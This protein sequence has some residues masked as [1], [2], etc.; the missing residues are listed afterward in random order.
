MSKLTD[1]VFSGDAKLADYINAYIGVNM[2]DLVC[3]TIIDGDHEMFKKFMELGVDV[4]GTDSSKNKSCM[5]MC[6][7]QKGR[8]EMLEI[9]LSRGM[10]IDSYAESALR[11]ITNVADSEFSENH[12]KCI[13]ILIRA[14]VSVDSLKDSSN[15]KYLLI[16]TIKEL[17]FEPK[18]L[19][20]SS[21]LFC[22]NQKVSEV[23]DDV[24][25]IRAVYNK[26]NCETH[27][28]IMNVNYHYIMIYDIF[29][30]PV[31][32]VSVYI[33][34]NIEVPVHKPAYHLLPAGIKV[35]GK[36]ITSPLVFRFVNS[37]I[38]Y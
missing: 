19:P 5:M 2:V 30:K 18:I 27:K 38:A 28:L 16:K 35:D 4:N 29:G 31:K 3:K 10:L 36:T 33:C 37:I 8:S 9:L 12:L 26:E 14:G 1:F 17:M 34:T 6:A 32:K 23:K 21:E 22:G 24:N 7:V 20:P 11:R 25:I 13:K 15:Q